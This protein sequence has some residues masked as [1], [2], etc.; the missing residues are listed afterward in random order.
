MHLNE[1]EFAKLDHYVRSSFGLNMENKQY[2][3]EARLSAELVRGG[4][5]SFPEYWSSLI[6]DKSGAMAA[7]LSD[8]LTTNYTYFCREE[9]HFAY[10]RTAL[11]PKLQGPLSIWCAGCATG[12]ESYTLAMLLADSRDMGR[13]PYDYH[14]IATD[15][16]NEAL[17]TAD[18]GIYHQ[19]DYERLPESWR[20]RYCLIQPDGDF[21]VATRIR[22]TVHY[23]RQNLMDTRPGS[24]RFDFV[25]CRNVLIYFRDHERAI[26][27]Q[28]LFDSLKP[29]G[30]L[31][32]GHA[33]SLLS[34]ETDFEYIIPAIYRKPEGAKC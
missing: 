29:G 2:L 31:F 24:N 28:N 23:M 30:L 34:C 3:V 17:E 6:L 7:R 8:C 15:L 12:Q 26:V 1:D 4:Y 11:L 18:T 5:S 13:L 32:I 20:K 33:E 10:I 14:I 25:F 27:V 16:S 22:D 21:I 9:K 19:A